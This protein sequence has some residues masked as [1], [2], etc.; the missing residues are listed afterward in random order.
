M[1]VAC[2]AVAGTAKAGACEIAWA[3]PGQIEIARK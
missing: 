3:C 2:Q 1:I